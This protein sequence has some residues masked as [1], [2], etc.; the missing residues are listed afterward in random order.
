MLVNRRPF[1]T[2][3]AAGALAASLFVA[4]PAAAVIASAASTDPHPT[5]YDG[6]SP[7]FT[8]KPLS[9]SL[10]SSIDAAT[11]VDPV[12]LCAGSP[13]NFNIPVKMTWAGS[14]AVSGIAGYDVWEVGPALDGVGKVVEGT[15]ATSYSYTG[16]NYDGDCGGGQE[17]DNRF[18]V[19]VKD[20]RGNSSAT[21]T[22]GQRVRVW[23]ETG[24]TV[25]NDA[26]L[27]VTRTGTWST[28]QCTCWNNGRTLFSKAPGASLTYTVKTTNPGANVAVAMAK[29]TNRGV[30][31]I[32][33]DGGTA[34][35]V[36][37]FASTP[38]HRVIVWQKVFSPGTH[39]IKVT[40]AGTAGRSRIDVDA[41][42][43]LDSPGGP[44]PEPQPSR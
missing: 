44:T 31:H 43:L 5:K 32:S 36:D 34:K 29:N 21:T 37:T 7:A 38:T 26:A 3:F 20:N 23:Q 24:T 28:S 10:G 9:F 1:F 41:V 18:W 42:L 40:N 33:V 16:G 6:T 8:M 4:V 14:D 2:P 12:N 35:A 11:P 27:P 25:E 30:A 17:F 15:T 39:A 13:W 22:R 19:V